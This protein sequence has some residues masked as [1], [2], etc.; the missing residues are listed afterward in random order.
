MAGTATLNTDFNQ[1]IFPRAS[2]PLGSA[3]L[4][5]SDTTPAPSSTA[6]PQSGARCD[7]VGLLS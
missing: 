2:Y 3:F 6:I 7:G 1:A 5:L 4:A